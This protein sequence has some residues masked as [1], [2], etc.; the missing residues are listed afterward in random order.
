MNGERRKERREK[1][2]EPVSMSVIREKHS[3][4]KSRNLA[5]NARRRVDVSQGLVLIPDQPETRELTEMNR[6]ETQLSQFQLSVQRRELELRLDR[7]E[8]L[9]ATRNKKTAMVYRYIDGHLLAD[10]GWYDLILR[11]S[12]AGFSLS[13]IP[14]WAQVAWWNFLNLG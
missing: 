4:W 11:R 12:P 7:L 3:N 8:D 13:Y 9:V 10:L 6:R 2:S 1:E 5:T 14:P